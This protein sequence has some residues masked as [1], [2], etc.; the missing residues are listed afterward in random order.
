[1]TIMEL[2]I[3]KKEYTKMMELSVICLCSCWI[4]S[5]SGAIAGFLIPIVIMILVSILHRVLSSNAILSCR[6]IVSFWQWH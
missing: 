4:K 2:M 1:M 3:S 5:G 6:S